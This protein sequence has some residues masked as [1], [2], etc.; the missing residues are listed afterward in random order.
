MMLVCVQVSLRSPI[1]VRSTFPRRFSIDK[2]KIFP[3]IGNSFRDGLSDPKSKATK[4]T[5]TKFLCTW[6]KCKLRSGN[7]TVSV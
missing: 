5:Y 4:L 3:Y 2:L 6:Q 7:I 1:T